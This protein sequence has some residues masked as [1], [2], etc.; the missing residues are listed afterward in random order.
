MMRNNVRRTIAGGVLVDLS[1]TATIGRSPADVNEYVAGPTRD[2]NWRTGTTDSGTR[3]EG[4]L[5][6][7]KRMELTRETRRQTLRALH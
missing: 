6:T 2:V 7:S 1:A 5:G 4:P 3:S